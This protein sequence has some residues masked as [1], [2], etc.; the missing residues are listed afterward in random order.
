MPGTGSSF[1]GR[2]RAGA[3]VGAAEA[4]DGTASVPSPAAAATPSDV[5][6]N[7]RRLISVIVRTPI[8]SRGGAPGQNGHGAVQL[9]LG[10][11]EGDAGRA[12][13][14]LGAHLLPA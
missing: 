14:H 13:E 12:V 7:R 8:G 3:A 9:V 4:A 2:C 1:G 11:A 6:I 5:P 10:L